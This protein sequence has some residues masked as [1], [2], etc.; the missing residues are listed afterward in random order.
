MEQKTNS[1]SARDLADTVTDVVLTSER[2]LSW[3]SDLRAQLNS[4]E[5]RLHAVEKLVRAI[6]T[7][8]SPSDQRVNSPKP[9]FW[10]RIE[11][12]DLEEKERAKHVEEKHSCRC[13]K[14]CTGSAE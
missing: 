14:G 4:L 2:L 7:P 10:K 5:L 3:S 11:K 13:G 12:S 1:T 6:S 9:P 8:N